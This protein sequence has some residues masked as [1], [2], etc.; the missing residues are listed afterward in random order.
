MFAHIFRYEWLSLRQN[1]LF[2]GV[3]GFTLLLCLLALWSGWQHYQR[4]KNVLAALQ[5]YEQTHYQE[6]ATQLESIARGEPFKGNPHINPS[7]PTTM[8]F[9][10]GFRFAYREPSAMQVLNV[11]QSDLHPYYYKVTANKEQGLYHQSEIKNGTLRFIGTFDLSF[12]LIYLLPLLVIAFSFDMLANDKSGGVLPYLETSRWS[13]PAILFSRYLCRLLL[14]FGS[15]WG[16]VV[17]FLAIAFQGL[18]FVALTSFWGWTLLLLGYLAFWFGLSFMVNMWGKSAHYNAS[19]LVVSWLVVVVLLP[20]IL[21]YLSDVAYPAPNRAAL[22]TQTRE[23]GIE[24]QKRASEALNDYIE[25]HPELAANKE[26]LNLQDF[27]TRYFVQ[28]QEVEKALAPTK[29]AFERQQTNRDQLIRGLAILS[30]AL[31]AQELS[32]ELSATTNQHYQY[33]AADALA[34]QQALRADLVQKIF[35]GKPMLPVDLEALPQFR[36]SNRYHQPQGQWLLAGFG[37]LWVLALGM[38]LSGFWNFKRFRVRLF[39]KEVGV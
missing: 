35:L 20:G 6:L 10:P 26:G 36:P 3:F 23:A 18:G 19:V 11:G 33:L 5:D 25:D 21:Q 17:V 13:L 29:A 2:L 37:L 31:L 34:L 4:Q 9:G 16:L 22:V 7:K 32:N 14:F 1:R 27:G 30:P 8:A 39:S 12:V 15:V 24:V 38:A 28:M